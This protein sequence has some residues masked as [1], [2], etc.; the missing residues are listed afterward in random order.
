MDSRLKGAYFLTRLCDTMSLEIL[1]SNF[2][3]KKSNSKR[4]KVIPTSCGIALYFLSKIGHSATYFSL[5]LSLYI[6]ICIYIY[7]KCNFEYIFKAHKIFDCIGIYLP[8]KFDAFWY[9]G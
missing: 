5:S 2:E 9:L 7:I 1:H 6:Y 4:K 8:K 3:S